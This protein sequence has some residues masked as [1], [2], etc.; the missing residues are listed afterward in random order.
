[1]LIFRI[2]VIIASLFF[3]NISLAEIYKDFTPFI[4]LK[5][6]KEHYPNAKF[7]EVKA[8]W[9]KK[10]E[11]LIKLTGSGLAG[12]TYLALA[13]SDSEWEK[14]ISD[15]EIKVAENPNEENLEL[16]AIIDKARFFL[17]R[18]LDEKLLLNWLRW[19]P[20]SALPLERLINRYGNPDV[21]GVDDESFQQYCD[22]TKRKIKANLSDDKKMVFTIEYG[23]TLEEK[24]R[25]LGINEPESPKVENKTP[26]TRN[27]KKKVNL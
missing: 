7:E 19:S 21:Y 18:P 26:T 6:I 10:D 27:K 1:M 14:E 13:T 12:T 20:D 22:W 15:S 17:N 8:A 4:S 9:V 3:S 25:A 16:L 2:S 24:Y 5:K 11:S 23:F